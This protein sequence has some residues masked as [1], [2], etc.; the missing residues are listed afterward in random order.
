MLAFR[1]GKR[2]KP[3]P[4]IGLKSTSAQSHEEL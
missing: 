3:T 1:L 4:P 2:R